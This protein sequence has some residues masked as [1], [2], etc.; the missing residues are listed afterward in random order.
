MCLLLDG[1]LW[2][3]TKA[4]SNVTVVYHLYLDSTSGDFKLTALIEY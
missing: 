1:T 4:K 2:P 3:Q